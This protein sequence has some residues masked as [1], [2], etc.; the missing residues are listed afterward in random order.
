M[1]F[2]N[3]FASIPLE[4][5]LA[6][7][8]A[9][10]LVAGVASAATPKGA[11]PTALSSTLDVCADEASGAWRYSGVVAVQDVDG[12]V[13]VDNRIQNQQS[14]AGYADALAAKSAVQ[15]GVQRAGGTVVVPYALTA[16]P[17]RL[18]VCRTRSTPPRPGSRAASRCRPAA[19]ASAACR[20]P[21]RGRW[22]CTTTASIRG[23]RSVAR[24]EGG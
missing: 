23:R 4:L 24:I 7:G 12:A 19:P 11:A 22:T 14:R 20:R 10:S 5:T 6:L 3:R 8:L 17:R 2:R 21:G 18:A 9:L 1:R 16:A 13:R 15:A